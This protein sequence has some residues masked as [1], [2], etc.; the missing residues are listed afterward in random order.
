MFF[1][2]E[3]GIVLIIIVGFLFAI[4]TPFLVGSLLSF[5]ILKRIFIDKKKKKY[6]KDKQARI[7]ISIF[8]SILFGYLSIVFFG[9][10]INKYII[11]LLSR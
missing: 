3:E 8:I 11:N 6:L 2:G 10:E 4:L 9:E 7:I 5:F 1:P